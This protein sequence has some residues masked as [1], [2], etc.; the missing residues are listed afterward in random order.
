MINANESNEMAVSMT[1]AAI[2]HVKAQIAK[3][4]SGMG[5]RLG[6]KH[7]GCSGFAYVLD[8]V[9]QADPE[10]HVYPID[11]GLSIC[12][13]PK[14]L[15]FVKG[16]RLDYVRQG[17]NSNFQFYNPNVKDTCGCGESFSV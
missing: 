16:T 9:E 2:R 6:V 13:D 11:E 7:T 3:R 15:P 12:I 5:M 8:Y 14:S 4:G 10:D 1:E 17:L